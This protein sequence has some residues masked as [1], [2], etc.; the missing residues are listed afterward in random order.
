MKLLLAPVLASAVVAST[1]MSVLQDNDF[2]AI[3][4]KVNSGD[5]TWVA[6]A[7]VAR[8]RFDSMD[9]V[10]ALCGT[11]M[12]DH[13]DYFRLPEA[14]EVFSED[15]YNVLDAED[16]PSDFDSR[17]QWSNCT[18]ISKIRDQSS[19]GSCWAFGSTEA[20]EDR[21]CV[22]TGKDTEFST[23]DTAA[24][25]SGFLCGMSMGCNG[26]QPSSALDWMTRSG[27]VTGGDYTDIGSGSTCKP[28][29][30]AP[31]AHHV[32]PSTKYPACPSSEYPT[33]RCEKKCSESGY[34]T[35]YSEDKTKASKAYSID[36]EQKIMSDIVQFGPVSAAFTVYSDF[37]TYK[38]GVYQHKTGQALGG[39]AIEIIGF[40]TESGTPYWLVKNSWNEEWGDGGTFKILRGSNECGI[41]GEISSVQF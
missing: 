36:G 34:Q 12:S 40:G 1:E 26:G 8:D 24:C 28:Y 35:S 10:R 39:H 32:P 11:F 41:E 31:C 3:Q 22:A 21:R 5:S 14:S 38:S 13:A 19:C 33:P 25:C 20:F 4:A 27:V 2:D 30:L 7:N 9:D 6:D 23:E 29:S 37:P 18:V 15:E 16:I 17:T